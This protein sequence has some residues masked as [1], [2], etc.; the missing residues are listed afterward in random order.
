MPQPVKKR[1][2]CTQRKAFFHVFFGPVHGAIKKKKE[3]R[4][5]VVNCV[6]HRKPYKVLL[7][8]VK[9]GRS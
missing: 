2:R 4:S 1:K 5:I 7:Y 3:R 8:A 9:S 6:K